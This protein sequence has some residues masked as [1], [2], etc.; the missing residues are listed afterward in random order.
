MVTNG[1]YTL[2]ST[3]VFDSHGPTSGGYVLAITSHGNIVLSDASTQ[4]SSLAIDATNAYWSTLGTPQVTIVGTPLSNPGTPTVYARLPEG[5]KTYQVSFATDGVYLYY[6]YAV[7]TG[8][9]GYLQSFV[10]YVAIGAGVPSRGTSGTIQETAPYEGFDNTLGE[11]AASN[12]FVV[13]ADMG[14]AGRPHLWAVR[15]R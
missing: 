4:P 9:P 8:N 7:P 14:F 1:E 5:A 3:E 11:L 13:W 15:F 6:A 10:D 12:G 2:V